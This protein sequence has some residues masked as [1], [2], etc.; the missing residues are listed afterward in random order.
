MT[1]VNHFSYV[2]SQSS[3]E[4][5]GE[6]WSLSYGEHK[7]KN[8]LFSKFLNFSL[9]IIG[10]EYR[11]RVSNYN[12][13]VVVTSTNWTKKCTCIGMDRWEMIRYI[14][15]TSNSD[16]ETSFVILS[17]LCIS[18][19]IWNIQ[20][21]IVVHLIYVLKFN[22]L[23]KQSSFFTLPRGRLVGN[24]FIRV[25]TSLFLLFIW[26]PQALIELPSL[27]QWAFYYVRRNI[28]L[29]FLW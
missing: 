19:R 29:D 20:L 2:C 23:F 12:Y 22:W 21:T 16:R 13:F 3:R 10:H 6:K 5:N 25:F 27:W 7:Q 8:Q 9:E 1:N 26:R 17:K 18:V 24:I 28:S 4:P 15:I 11:Q 14:F